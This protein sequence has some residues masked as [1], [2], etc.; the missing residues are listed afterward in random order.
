MFKDILTSK[1][2]NTRWIEFGNDVRGECLNPRKNVFNSMTIKKSTIL[3]L[4]KWIKD[5]KELK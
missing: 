4:A 2:E 3:K 1:S 5:N